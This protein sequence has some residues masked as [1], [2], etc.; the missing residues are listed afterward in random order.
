MPDC[1]DDSVLFS[2]NELLTEHERQHFESLAEQRHQQQQR[3]RDRELAVKNAAEEEQRR[4]LA[5]QN[6]RAQ[7]QLLAREVEARIV[8]FREAE[9][10]RARIKAQAEAQSELAQQTQEHERR[11]EAF[12]TDE[13]TRRWR[14]LAFG[15]AGVTLLVLGVGSGTYYGRILPAAKAKSVGY[16]QR[17]AAQQASLD[18]V[19]RQLDQAETRAERANERVE[20][21]ARE[22]DSLKAQNAI[23]FN[24]HA[25]AG[26]IPPVRPRQPEQERVRTPEGGCKDDGDPLNGCLAR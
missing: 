16:E 17:L 15:L 12:R 26:R 6:R 18:N 19:S 13:R 7:Q 23:L 10:E 14:L 4:V 25:R 2:L 9:V 11:L 3:V 5:E 22:R 21:L 1:Q 20:V 24:A 8:A